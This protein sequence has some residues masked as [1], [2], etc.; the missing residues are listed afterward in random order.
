M[1]RGAKD[2]AEMLKVNGSL[3]KMNLFGNNISA[4]GAK[5]L[6]EAL[7]VNCSLEYINLGCNNIGDKAQNIWQTC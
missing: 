4:E 1:Y 2:L 7:T 5:W 6:A 3:K